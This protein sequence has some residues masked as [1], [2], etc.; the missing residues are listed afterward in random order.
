VGEISEDGVVLTALS[1]TGAFLV[2]CRRPGKAEDGSPAKNLKVCTARLLQL[3]LP[4]PLPHVLTFADPHK[5]HDPWI[6]HPGPSLPI[7]LPGFP[8]GLGAGH[9][10]LRVFSRP[11]AGGQGPLAGAALDA[12]RQRIPAH[13]HQ[14]G[15]RVRQERRIQ[16]CV[17]FRRACVFVC[18][19]GES[20]ASERAGL[21]RRADNPALMETPPKHSPPGL[22]MRRTERWKVS[23]TVA[24]RRRGNAASLRVEYGV[25]SAGGGRPVVTAV[26]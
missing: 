24:E 10:Q 17:R 11:E 1:S 9:R 22:G 7:G 25:A 3:T 23:E 5:P 8:A 26:T 2:T 18:V 19:G 20:Y 4:R 6:R 15:A 21:W 16:R 12:R 13:G 14:H